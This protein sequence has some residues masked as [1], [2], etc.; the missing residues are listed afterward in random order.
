MSGWQS[1][2]PEVTALID[3][4]WQGVFADPAQGAVL[5]GHAA[6]LA[7]SRGE[8]FGQAYGALH[9]ALSQA[10]C[11]PPEAARAAAEDAAR[12]CAALG[13]ET[14]ALSCRDVLALLCI[15]EGRFAEAIEI[16]ERNAGADPALRAPVER[17]LTLVLLD[18]AC[19]SASRFDQAL[20][21]GYRATALART[22][23]GHWLAIALL[24]LA[25]DHFSCM[26]FDDGVPLHD[27]SF[28]L[29]RRLGGP[30]R[31][32]GE[33]HASRIFSRW[34]MHRED[35][36]AQA[37][38]AWRAQPG[39]ITPDQLRRHDVA[40]AVGHLAAGL[41]DEA[42][43]CLAPDVTLPP[44]DVHHEVARIWARA[45]LL[46]ARGQARPA[47]ELCRRYLD[48]P[49]ARD[50]VDSPSNLVQL[51]ETQ[52]RCHEALGDWD[53]AH[54]AARAAH[55]AGLPMLQPKAQARYLAVQMRHELAAGA[56]SHA[57]W[58]AHQR[59][60]EAIVQCVQ[61]PALDDGPQR[62]R[63]AERID[64]ILDLGRIDA[65]ALRL[66]AERFAPAALLQDC[67]A[68]L[69][70]LADERRTALELQVDPALPD[71]LEGAV[72][73]L[74]QVLVNLLRNALEHAP[75]KPV[76]VRVM[77]RGAC[78]GLG[79]VRYCGL[80]FEVRDG[81]RGIDAEVRPTLF[82]ESEGADGRIRLGLALCRRLV[83]LMDGEIGVEHPSGGGCCVWFQLNLVVA[84]GSVG[85][86][87]RRR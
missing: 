44:E 8:A 4:A 67:A 62:V 79:D 71:E 68:L 75:G 64:D 56:A 53:G 49:Q 84:T 15:N 42:E 34:E 39:G 61:Q 52:R 60:L 81:G 66:E 38:A 13:V 2:D 82:T 35:L 33:L 32:I 36:A 65:G 47:L 30:A 48:S 55:L 25:A 11:T 29:T 19:R 87:R 57:C 73:R 83:E 31:R 3:Q 86:K 7:Q 63:Q 20:R 27:E 51:H 85:A 72:P 78:V 40:L 26:N 80:R 41:L 24:N 18:S 43:L 9:V 10:L 45:R 22:L 70:P 54:A 37:L 28:E 16:G 74:R 23:G 76:S 69:R 5:G 77:G 46:L 6:A 21:H 14:A 12:L 1:S 58:P 59:R 50:H 17:C